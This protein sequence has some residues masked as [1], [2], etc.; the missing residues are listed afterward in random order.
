VYVHSWYNTANLVSAL[1]P[2]RS[3]LF[4]MSF[5][6]KVLGW[7]NDCHLYIFARQFLGPKQPSISRAPWHNK[8]VYILRNPVSSQFLPQ[9]GRR[10]LLKLLHELFIIFHFFMSFR[11]VFAGI[12]PF[13]RASICHCTG[14]RFAKW[15][16]HRL[17]GQL[18]LSDLFIWGRRV[19]GFVT[20][21]EKK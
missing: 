9:T 19:T 20:Q 5:L 13:F 15:G 8:Y 12:Q 3:A 2:F 6:L 1:S 4:F 16:L 7:P 14:L 11:P 17:R 21:H 18:V 10:Q